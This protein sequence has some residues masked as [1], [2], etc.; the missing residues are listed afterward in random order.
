MTDHNILPRRLHVKSGIMGTVLAW[1]QSYISNRSQCI[2]LG[3][4]ASALAQCTSGVLQVSVLGPIVFAVYTSP[5]GDLTERFGIHH[6]QF[7]DDTQIHLALR[8][9]DIQNGLAHCRVAL[10]QWYLRNG[11]LLNDDKSEAICTGTS[12]QLCSS[13]TAANTVIVVGAMLPTGRVKNREGSQ[14]QQCVITVVR[15]RT[16]CIQCDSG[17]V[18]C[19]EW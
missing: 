17:T 9:C 2:K 13:S 10:K 15:P 7:A 1:L 5:V 8:S 11:L 12:A 19:L 6:H 14:R 16:T 4:Y 3:K 18:C